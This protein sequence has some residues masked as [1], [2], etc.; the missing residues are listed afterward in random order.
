MRFQSSIGMDFDVGFKPASD[1][2]N[3]SS[4][5]IDARCH[6]GRSLISRCYHKYPCRLVQ[7]PPEAC[8]KLMLDEGYPQD[9]IDF[10]YRLFDSLVLL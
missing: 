8:K 5:Y 4:L 3:R 9:L 7:T 6:R 1:G 2:T 10:C